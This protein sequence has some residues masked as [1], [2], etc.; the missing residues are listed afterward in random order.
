MGRE[1]FLLDGS[2]PSS[3]PLASPPRGFLLVPLS[4]L[5]AAVSGSLLRCLS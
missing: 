2:G 3:L 1:G 4:P 5:Q